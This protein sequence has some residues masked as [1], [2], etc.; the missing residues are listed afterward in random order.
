MQ[1]LNAGTLERCS[2]NQNTERITTARVCES[3]RREG[4]SEGYIAD[5]LLVVFVSHRVKRYYW[6]LIEKAVLHLTLWS[7]FKNMHSGSSSRKALGNI[8][9]NV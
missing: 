7:K 6:N 1:P 9:F 5:V 3:R 4:R 8:H 2:L